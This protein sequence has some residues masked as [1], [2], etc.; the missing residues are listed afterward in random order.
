V[1]IKEYAEKIRFDM[2]Q[3]SDSGL[4]LPAHILPSTMDMRFVTLPAQ[5]LETKL[6]LQPL[7]EAT[8]RMGTFAI[9]AIINKCVS[10]LKEDTVFVNV[11]T[12]QGF[13]LFCGM[14]GNPDKVC[15]GIDNFS[16]FS[17]EGLKMEFLEKFNKLKSG[18][19]FFYEEDYREYFSGLKSKIGFYIYDGDHS[20]E[21]QCEG[22]LVAEPFF[23][24][25]C[26]I[27][28]DDMNVDD[29]VNGTT[30]FLKKTKWKYEQI[31]TVQ[32]AHDTHPTWWNGITLIRRRK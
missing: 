16:Q 18:C 13:S 5:D 1:N 32:T 14:A 3:P 7:M 2:I 8:R 19:H 30:D 10:E 28:V 24:D 29:V 17:T 9:G 21:N 12:W 25:D 4:T 15:V 23:S 26:I 22:L 20:R 11:G 6:L 31:F 27:L